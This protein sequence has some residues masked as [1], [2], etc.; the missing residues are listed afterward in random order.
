MRRDGIGLRYVGGPW[1]TTK[2][3]VSFNGEDVTEKHRVAAADDREG[4]LA[5]YGERGKPMFPKRI[6]GFD[7]IPVMIMVGDVVMTEVAE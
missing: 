7:C 6:N 2:L 3:R 5:T 4:W 1:D